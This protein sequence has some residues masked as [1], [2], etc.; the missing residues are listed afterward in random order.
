MCVVDSKISISSFGSQLYRATYIKV[1]WNIAKIEKNGGDIVNCLLKVA[2]FY[3]IF[4]NF[5]N[6]SVHL[7]EFS[8]YLTELFIEFAQII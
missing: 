6:I 4:Q 8:Q 3:G 1:Q 7:S 5:S 2:S